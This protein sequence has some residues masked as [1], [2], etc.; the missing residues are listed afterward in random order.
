MQANV[1]CVPEHARDKPVSTFDLAMNA[2]M[3]RIN[4]VCFASVNIMV[5]DVVQRAGSVSTARK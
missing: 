3:E 5:S 4:S 1:L 2:M